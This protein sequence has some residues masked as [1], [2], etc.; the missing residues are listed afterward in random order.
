MQPSD[1]SDPS[2]SSSGQHVATISHDG[3][4]WDVYLDFED[5]PRHP[6]TYRGYLSF[7]AADADEEEAMFRT[8]AIIVEDSYEEA[9]RK[10]RSFEEHHLAGLLRSARP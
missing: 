8:A 1:P 3:R 4:F 6:E 5:D 10:A 9:V 7:S 2:S